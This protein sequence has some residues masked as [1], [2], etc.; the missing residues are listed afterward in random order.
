V[1]L[2]AEPPLKERVDPTE[3]GLP[4]GL[5]PVVIDPAY[6]I[7]SLEMRARYGMGV[8]NRLNGVVLELGTGG[9]YSIP[10]AFASIP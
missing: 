2:E 7:Q 10:S 8:A 9:T 4:R 6:P 5:T 1:H 3:T